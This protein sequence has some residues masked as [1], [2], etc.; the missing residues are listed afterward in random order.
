MQDNSSNRK[1]VEKIQQ[2]NRILLATHI[3]PDGDAVGS[4]LGLGLALQEDG[5]QVQ[6]VIEDGIPPSLRRLADSNSG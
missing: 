3:R 2:S 4:L 5:R 1:A 6:M